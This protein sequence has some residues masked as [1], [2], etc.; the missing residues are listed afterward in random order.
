ME[1]GHAG[2][3]RGKKKK[4]T[5]SK[6]VGQGVHDREEKQDR[7]MHSLATKSQR[8]TTWVGSGWIGLSVATFDKKKRKLKILKKSF[9]MPRSR[10]QKYD[11]EHVS[12]LKH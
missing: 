5:Q 4:H 6:W 9:T 11:C 10:P 7:R 3:M 1:K 8:K 12:Q 2:I